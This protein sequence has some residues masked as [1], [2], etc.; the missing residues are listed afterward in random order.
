MSEN[1]EAVSRPS[2]PL[3]GEE[4]TEQEQYVWAQ[5]A[6][7]EIANLLTRYQGS[8]DPTDAEGWPEER[9]LRPGFLETILFPEFEATRNDDDNHPHIYVYH[10]HTPI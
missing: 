5:V 9:V 10:H 7:G 4:W 8:D 3:P 2:V 6:Q 1:E